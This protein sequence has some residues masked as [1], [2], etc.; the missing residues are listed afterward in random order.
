[1]SIDIHKYG[2]GAIFMD[3]IVVCIYIYIY[4]Y[5]TT[6]K[7][8]MMYQSTEITS[9]FGMFM[10]SFI[11]IVCQAWDITCHGDMNK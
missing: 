3:I 6:M 5:T 2:F 11:E 8:S 10:I 1:M 9:F 4:V 7:G